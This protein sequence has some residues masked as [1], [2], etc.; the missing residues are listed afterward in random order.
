M[1]KSV[2]E[3]LTEARAKV[4][5]GWCQGPP[6]VDARGEPAYSAGDEACAWCA[7]GA[8][9]AVAFYRDVGY[10]ASA[11]LDDEAELRGFNNSTT[12]NEAPGRTQAEVVDLFTKAI[13]KAKE[14]AS[15]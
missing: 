9:I 2:I 4:A 12:F 5:A 14:Q 8:I 10:E 3:V 1:S 11:A 15:V 7:W 6:A 13:E